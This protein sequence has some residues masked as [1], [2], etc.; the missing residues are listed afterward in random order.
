MEPNQQPEP[1]PQKKLPSWLTTVTP[2]SKALAMI[3]FIILPFLG[4]YLGMQYQQKITVS[5]PEALEVQKN[6]TPMPTL[7]QLPSTSTSSASLQT[8]TEVVQDFYKSYFSC[9]ANPPAGKDSSYCWG[10][11]GFTTSDFLKNL[12]PNTN[13]MSGSDPIF[14]GN[15]NMPTDIKIEKVNI[16]SQAAT[17]GVNIFIGTNIPSG[18]ISV[19]LRLENNNWLVSNVICPRP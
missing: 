16:Q 2:F 17:V 13:S 6:I 12:S 1:V 5:V 18:N 9:F 4:F 15:G 10:H 7:I 14:C 3:V 19:S 8:L 11:T